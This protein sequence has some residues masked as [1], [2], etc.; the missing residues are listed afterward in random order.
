MFSSHTT[1]AIR[2]NENE[3][4]LLA[5]FKRLLD[6]LAPLGGYEHDDMSRREDVPPDEPT[7]GHAHCQQLLLSSSETLPVVGEGRRQLRA[8][9][10]G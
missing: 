3:P 7:N 4:L 2:I 9:A 1:A 6:R 5:D 10:G 8:F